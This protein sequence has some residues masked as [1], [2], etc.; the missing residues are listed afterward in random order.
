MTQP[1]P[2]LALTF[3]LITVALDAIGIGLIFA[4]GALFLLAAAM[5]IV[6]AGLMSQI[7]KHTSPPTS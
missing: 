2:R 3:I 4:P 5:M 6:C 7:P 1:D